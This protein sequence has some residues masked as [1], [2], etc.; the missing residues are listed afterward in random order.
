M[1]ELHNGN[2]M[3]Y[4]R[5]LSFASLLFAALLAIATTRAQSQW[6][7]PGN[8]GKLVYKATARGDRIPDF[9]S[10][11][12]RGGG[13]ALP[14]AVT[15]EKVSTTGGPDDTPAI[16]AALDK[17]AKLP[18]GANGIRGAVELTPGTF[19]LAGTLKINAGGLVLR[20]AGADGARATVLE[21]TGAPHKAMEIRGEYHKS[22]LGPATVL[23]DAY[24]PAGALAIHV[25]DASAI[26]A[27]DLLEIVKP[28]TPEWVHF[29]GMDHLVRD[30]KPET[31]V[32]NDIRVRRRVASVDGNTVRLT[33]PLTDSFDAHFFGG[34]RATVT[35][36]EVTGQIAEVGV[37]NLRIAAPDRTINY[38]EDAEFDGI[39]MDDV[40]DCWL[41]DLKFQDTTDS[42]ILEQGVERATIVNV[43]VQQ[44]SAV[45]SHAQPFDFRINGSQI[46]LDRCSATG[47]RVSYVATQSR[48]EGPVVVLHCRFDGS[49]QV[50]GHQRWSTGLLVD[51]SEVP[52][53]SINLRN[54]GEMGTGHGWAIG[55]SVSWNNKAAS[56]LVQNP[57]GDMNWSIGDAGEHGTA[58]MPVMETPVGPVLPSGIVESPGKHVEPASLYLEQ[59][60]ERLGPAA[61]AAIGYH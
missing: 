39:D 22:D 56:F 12:Y 11:G 19:H 26:H 40:A 23:T 30:G 16:Q 5:V 14:T 25:A 61:V 21:M 20:G 43:D 35:R 53:G 29:M 18:P 60:R 44:H 46:L 50:E 15:H 31:W 36:V 37:E 6:V 32:K 48:S 27:G 42:V 17:L 58:P 8:N 54:R 24:V 45:T 41:R 49:G 10:A 55:W 33:V 7:H 47:D 59:L 57:P 2:G 4:R 38:R 9:S 1:T 51:S 52:D 3:V 28:V 13:V 34:K